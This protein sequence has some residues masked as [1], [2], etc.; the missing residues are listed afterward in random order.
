M[1]K[2]KLLPCPFCGGEAKFAT[3]NHKW[4][5]CTKCEME[6]PYR[7][8]EE[9]LVALWNNRKPVDEMVEQIHSYFKSVI[10]KS[11]SDNV[12]LE[13][14]EYNKAICDIVRGGRE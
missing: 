6:T 13:V 8:S 9:E 7:E 14:L 10:E 11:V 3:V 5:E 2:I 1:S 12:P 4:I